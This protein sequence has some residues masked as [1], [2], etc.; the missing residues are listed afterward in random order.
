MGEYDG[1]GINKSG[2]E[3]ERKK[4]RNG[5]DYPYVLMTAK[6]GM[7]IWRTSGPEKGAQH[8]QITTNTKLLEELLGTNIRI[9]R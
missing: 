7:V 4:Q 1:L 8:M 2:G 9:L 3:G 6:H 5:C